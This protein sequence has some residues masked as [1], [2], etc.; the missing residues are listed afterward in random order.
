MKTEALKPLLRGHLHQAAFFI[1]IGACSLLVARTESPIALMCSIVFSLGL[2]T[3]FGVSALYHRPNWDPKGRAVMKRLDHSAIFLLIAGTFTPV[4]LMALPP[5]DGPTLLTIVWA[6]AVVGIFQAVFWTTAPKWFT[7]TFYI[8]I[9]WLIAPYWND[10]KYSLGP[11]NLGL[12]AAGGFAYTLGAIFYATKRPKLMP[13][14]FG[15]HEL[16]HALTIVGAALHFAVVYA[17]I[18]RS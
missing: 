10:L 12:L 5:G 9:G 18:I 17:L 7:A 13:E 16:F 14:I 4:C 15:Y 3:L 11:L 6:A 8:A 2:L 1:S